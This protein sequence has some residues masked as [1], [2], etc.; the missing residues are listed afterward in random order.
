MKQSKQLRAIFGVTALAIL[1]IALTGCNEASSGTNATSA[2]AEVETPQSALSVSLVAPRAEQ[3]SDRIIATGSI[4]PWQE[5]SIGA[6]ISGERL[7]E[8]LVS[9]GDPVKKGQVLAR[10]TQESTLVELRMQQASLA[11]AEANLD[12]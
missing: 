5:A 3:W 4:E 6:E 8:V 2:V 9:V 11:E 1:P 12:N 10:L 7:L